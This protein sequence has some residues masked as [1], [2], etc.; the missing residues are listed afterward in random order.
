MAN[1]Q[2]TEEK[3][4]SGAKLAIGIFGFMIGLIVILW[5]VKRFFGM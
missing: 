3:K 5:L 4:Q 2:A 1:E